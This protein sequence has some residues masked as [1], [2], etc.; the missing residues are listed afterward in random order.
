MTEDREQPT[1]EPGNGP[2]TFNEFAMVRLKR[3]ARGFG[4]LY[5]AGSVGAIVHRHAD[6]IGYEVE[7]DS[8]KPGVATV[9]RDGLESA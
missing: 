1:S 9:V 7:F 5:P 4:V 2:K 3:P 6:G 8:P